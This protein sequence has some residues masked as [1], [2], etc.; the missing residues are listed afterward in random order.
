VKK[1]PL[2]D[3]SRPRANG[4]R[5]IDLRDGD[6]LVGVDIT[7]GDR[8]V[9]LFTSAGKAIRFNESNVRAMG[10][11]AGGVRGIKLA[12]DAKLISLIIAGEG[13]VLTATEN[14]YGKRTQMDQYPCHGRGGQ[15][16]IAIQGGERNGAVVGAVQVTDDDQ[17][18]L[19]TNGGTLVRTRVAEVSIQGRNTQGVRLINLSKDEKLVG[20][21]RVE[22]QD[23]VA[24][25]EGTEE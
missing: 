24:D 12:G 13:C 19:I 16:V 23:E 1:T 9:M 10:R 14:G 18:M 8:D 15:G 25:T 5:A 22:E 20:M 21:E 11:T 4:I 2:V 17:I 7:D 3:Y 6:Q